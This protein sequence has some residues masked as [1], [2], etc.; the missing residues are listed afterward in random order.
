VVQAAIAALGDL[1]VFRLANK[2]GGPQA[3]RYA[4][5]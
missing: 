2:V 4:V 3:A 1:Y 5:R